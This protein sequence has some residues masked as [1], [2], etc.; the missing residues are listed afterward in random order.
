MVLLKT[1]QTLQQNQGVV[2][3][4]KSDSRLFS[5]FVLDEEFFEVHHMEQKILWGIGIRPNQ[6]ERPRGDL[7]FYKN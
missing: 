7:A 5:F 1:L 2:H 3:F 4:Q 6:V